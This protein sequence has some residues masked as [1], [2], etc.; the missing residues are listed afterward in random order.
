ME[1]KSMEK[2]KLKLLLNAEP[3]GFGPTA[4]I[5]SI[6]P[7]LREGFEYMG[8]IGKNHTLDL[9]RGLP[10]E[11]VHDSTSMTPDEEMAIF[12][13]YDIL[14]TALDFEIAAKA[15]RV[16]LKVI[17]YD[18]LAWFWKTIPDILRETDLYLAQDFFG[19]AERLEK[20]PQKFPKTH[21]V[22]PIVSQKRDRKPGNIV[23]VNLGGLQNLLWADAYA[24]LYASTVVDMLLD[25]I[26]KDERIIITASRVVTERLKDPRIKNYTRAEMY[27]ILE[28]TKYAFMTPGLG[29][30]YDAA[31]FSIPT[32]WL[33]PANDSQGQQIEI[34]DAHHVVDARVDWKDFPGGRNIDY[35][36]RQTEVIK[37]VIKN[38]VELQTDDI[39]RDLF[40]KILSEKLNRISGQEKSVT[41]GLL[42][43]FGTGGAEK[44][45][46]L[47]Y[48][49]GK[50]LI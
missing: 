46:E 47:V 48:K 42:D 33:P 32:I 17:V 7:Y 20:E 5:A 16:G 49:F 44:I 50:S 26:P 22:P 21:I 27:E 23:L 25:I 4:A 24:E 38:I 45:A 36:D 35:H 9:Q 41:E 11:A 31:K 3:F 2:S 30:I 18:P 1:R 37:N 14:F 19:V 34:L 43:R 13:Q 6:F 10:Y 29:N 12:R 28:D 8:Y 40:R 39:H 15:K